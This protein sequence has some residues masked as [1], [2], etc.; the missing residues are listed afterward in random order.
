MYARDEAKWMSLLSKLI[1][2]GRCWVT[3]RI[4]HV[5]CGRHVYPVS[6]TTALS[7]SIA[8]GRSHSYMTLYH[9]PA[10]VIGRL[11]FR[12]RSA[13]LKSLCSYHIS[14]KQ[15]LSCKWRRLFPDPSQPAKL[16]VNRRYARTTPVHR[17]VRPC[18]ID[19][20]AKWFENCTE[21]LTYNYIAYVHHTDFQL[22][23]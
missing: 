23:K 14:T 15:T 5:G 11:W 4:Q 10:S 17:R 21:H 1:C 22:C 9:P 8:L 16:S 7:Y 12:C 13:K 19:Y 20:T 3:R 18:I 2:E 6:S